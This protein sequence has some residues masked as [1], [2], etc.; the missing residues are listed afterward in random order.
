MISN[1]IWKEYGRRQLAPSE[2]PE[3]RIGDSS[4]EFRQIVTLNP[5][6]LHSSFFPSWGLRFVSWCTGHIPLF[7]FHRLAPEAVQLCY[8][9]VVPWCSTRAKSGKSAESYLDLCI[10]HRT[11]NRPT[12]EIRPRAMRLATSLP[13]THAG[14]WRCGNVRTQGGLLLPTSYL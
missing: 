1:T 7:V 11:Y 4:P 6:K 9:T 5:G 12:F 14:R 10:A 3:W 2:A 13:R 8:T